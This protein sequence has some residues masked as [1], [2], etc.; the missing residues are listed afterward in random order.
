MVTY[1]KGS[2]GE[3]VLQ[4]QKALAGAGLKVI[5]DG[6]YGVITE[7]AV[8]EFQ[9]R[10]GITVDGIVG[11]KTLALLI[12]CRFKKSK[13]FIN[14]IIVH[15]SATP[16]GR[17]YTVDDI[18][19]WHK[20]RGFTDVGYHYIIYRNG[21]IVNG[22]DVDLIGAHCTNHNS[23]SI[24]V[25]Y[26]GGMDSANKNPKDTRTLAQKAALL[27]LLVDLK[28]LY[29]GAKIYGHRDFAN[30]ACPSFDATKEYRKV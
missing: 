10:K 12:P 26:I 8:K 29:P 13:R 19:S 27:S 18:R 14:E 17:D 21:H 23:H 16:E 24:G 22:R 5:Q 3:V 11:P 2:R 7:E 20:D 9:R 4:I 1:R 25:C 28:K 15:C 30:K 6:I